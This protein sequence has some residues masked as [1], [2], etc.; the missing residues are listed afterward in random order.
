MIFFSDCSG[1]CDDCVINYTGGCVAGH[2]D[3]DFTQVTVSDIP[4]ILKFASDNMI[5][6]LCENYPEFDRIIKLNKIKNG[7]V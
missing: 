2:G 5:E 1:K 3:D 6:R 7:K 4:Y